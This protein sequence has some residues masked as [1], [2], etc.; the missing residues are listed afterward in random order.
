MHLSK[1]LFELIARHRG[2]EGKDVYQCFLRKCMDARLDFRLLASAQSEV[3]SLGD[4]FYQ[5]EDCPPQM[6][7]VNVVQDVQAL[8][9]A[10]FET[11][12]C[13]VVYTVDMFGR[14]Q[15]VFDPRNMNAA[16]SSD[17]FGGAN[18]LSIIFDRHAQ[19]LKKTVRDLEGK[20][21]ME[22]MI[23]NSEVKEGSTLGMALGRLLNVNYLDGVKSVIH[24]FEHV[25]ELGKLPEKYQ[26][27]SWS[28]YLFYF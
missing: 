21:Q 5:D 8:C 24:L 15:T 4:R 26:A 23:G 25:K 3:E 7:R 11:A 13:F 2:A 1:Q 9:K 20:D 17:S 6:F 10:I 14:V 27:S 18:V 16:L 12:E 22:R 28:M 19:T